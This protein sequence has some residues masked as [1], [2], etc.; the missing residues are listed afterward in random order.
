[1]EKPK[2]MERFQLSVPKIEDMGEFKMGMYINT[3]IQPVE[4]LD[5]AITEEI[6]KMVKEKGINDVILLNKKAIVSA[7]DKQMPKLPLMR[8]F[9]EGR[10]INTISFT[11]PICHQHIGRENYCKHCGQALDWSD[12]DDR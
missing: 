11:C 6:I 12:T 5:D 3:L 4:S 2:F 9:R 1:M 8:G 7:L 10:E